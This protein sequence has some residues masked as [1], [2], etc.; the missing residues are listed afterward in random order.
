MT[1][2]QDKSKVIRQKML[3]DLQNSVITGRILLVAEIILF[4]LGFP[5]FAFHRYRDSRIVSGR[6]ASGCSWRGL[7]SISWCCSR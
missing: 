5:G 6:R 2:T 4:A 3:S 7:R 1:F